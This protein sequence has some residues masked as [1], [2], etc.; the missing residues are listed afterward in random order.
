[1]DY[2]YHDIWF[3]VK[4]NYVGDYLTYETEWLLL[5]KSPCPTETITLEM[6]PPPL[7]VWRY[8]INN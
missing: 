3:K 6:I 8:E 4:V 5:K 7:T 1:M 2:V